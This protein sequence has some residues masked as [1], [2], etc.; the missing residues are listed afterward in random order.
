MNLDLDSSMCVFEGTT[1]HTT[2]QRLV[3]RIWAWAAFEKTVENF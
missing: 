2:Q 3:K 1:Q